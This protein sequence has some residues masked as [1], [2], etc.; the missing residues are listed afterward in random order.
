MSVCLG[1]QVPCGR[2]CNARETAMFVNAEVEIM[3]RVY[4]LKKYNLSCNK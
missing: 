1:V 2:D 4:R 3:G